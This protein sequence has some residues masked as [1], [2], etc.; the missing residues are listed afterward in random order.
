[1]MVQPLKDGTERVIVEAH[2]RIAICWGFNVNNVPAF[3]FSPV[4][5][6][7]HLGPASLGDTNWRIVF[8]PQPAGHF[9]PIG[10]PFE[11]FMA[12]VTCDG[13]LRAGSGYADGTPGFAQTRQTGVANTGVSTGCPP[14]KDG[15][16][17]PAEK[18][19]FKPRGN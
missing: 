12:S 2:T 13:V 7:N 18:V 6:A 15:D 17:F 14:E 3:G 1:M 5:V 4:S 10:A 19:Q 11:Q 16:C 9:N 8:A